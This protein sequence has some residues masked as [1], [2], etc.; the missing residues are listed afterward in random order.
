MKLR[1]LFLVEP[2]FHRLEKLRKL[3]L[4]KRVVE[5]FALYENSPLEIR[6]DGVEGI[7]MAD[8][9]PEY[10]FNLFVG[11]DEHFLEFD[12]LPLDE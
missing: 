11:L 5:Q 4:G 6:V 2:E 12:S 3:F 7:G 9:N 1:Q 10:G 8:D